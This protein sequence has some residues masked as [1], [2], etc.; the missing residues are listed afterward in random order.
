[1]KTVKQLN[2]HMIVD[3]NLPVISAGIVSENC[4]SAI[5]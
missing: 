5:T 1:M 4:N 2:I 3:I